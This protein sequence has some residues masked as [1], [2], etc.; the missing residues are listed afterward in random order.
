MTIVVRGNAELVKVAEWLIPD[1]KSMGADSV[2]REYRMAG[3]PDGIVRVFHLKPTLAI[4]ELQEVATLVR[5]ISDIRRLFTFNSTKAIAVRGTA[6]DMQ[7]AQWLIGELDKPAGKV[8]S[9]GDFKMLSGDVVRVF[10]VPGAQSTNELYKIATEVRT[11]TAV[12]RL[13]TYSAP[14][15]M[16]VRGTATQIETADRMVK[17]KNQ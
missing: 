11:T 16:A 3:L 15:A 5:S 4:Q 6:E 10:Y 17:E 8:T 1:F 13:F 9:P 14:K 2:G 7:L 12:R